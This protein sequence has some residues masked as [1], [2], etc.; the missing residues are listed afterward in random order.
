MDKETFAKFLLASA[1]VLGGWWAGSYFFMHEEKAAPRPPAQAA[2]QEIPEKPVVEEPEEPTSP[3]APAPPKRA[4]EP[5]EGLVVSNQHLR[6]EWTNVGAALQRLQLLDEQYKAPYKVGDERPPL[7]LL[8]GFEQGRYSDTLLGLTVSTATEGKQW[9]ADIP[10]ENLVYEVVEH[11][12]ERLIFEASLETPFEGVL[13]GP[14]GHLLRLRKTVEVGERHHLSVKLEITNACA[15]PLEVNC[16]VRGPAGIERE[17]LKTHYLGTRVGAREGPG[18]YKVAERS[19]GK[20]QR[21]DEE[22]N[23][24]A[25]IVWAGSVNHYFAAVY[26]LGEANWVDRVESLA[27]IEEDIVGAKGRWNK[28]SVRRMG[29]R[30]QL[31]KTPAVILRMTVPKALQAGSEAAQTYRIVAVPKE[32]E[33]L[34]AYDA[35]LGDLIDLGW[36]PA[37]SRLALGLLNFFHAL[38]PN[39]GVA[40]I[41]LTAFVRVILHPLTR[42]SQLS[43]AKMQKLQPKIAELQKQYSDDKEKLAQAQMELWKKYGVSPLSGCGP[44]LLQMP[45]LIALFGA[46]RAAIELRHAGFLWVPDLSQPDALF[47]LPFTIPIV[48]W[49]TFNLLPVIMAVVMFLNQ[50]FMSPATSEQAQQQQKIMKYFP[51][52]FVIILYQFPSGLC[53]Y[54]TCS[55][56]IGLLERWAIQRKADEMALKPVA[57]QRREKG[58]GPAAKEPKMGWLDKLQKLVEE[59]TGEGRGRNRKK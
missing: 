18:D 7:T 11:S 45:V 49:D 16:S 59:K 38:I 17:M 24:S 9:S 22:P 25:N 42:K 55:T 30:T 41:V 36:L 15:E 28:P 47:S 20:L 3:P 5:V 48:G 29:D 51:F 56:S 53:L 39:Y 1:V 26:L 23:E 2:R 14:E 58:T 19:A 27:L 31:A 35:G 46:L 6:A 21:T 13:Q 33:L 10:T 37:L 32:D 8:K 12:P 52:F 44:L 43:M 57:Q 50:K 34:E 54:L 4:A 40:I